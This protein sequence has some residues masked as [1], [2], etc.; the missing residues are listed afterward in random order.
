MASSTNL[1]ICSIDRD[2]PIFEV[3]PSHTVRLVSVNM[4][5]A[6]LFFAVFLSWTPRSDAN[7]AFGPITEP[8]AS[9]VLRSRSNAC[10]GANDLNI[11]IGCVRGFT[12]NGVDKWLGVPFASPPV[13][14]RRFRAP[15]PLRRTSGVIDATQP[16]NCCWGAV[17]YGP[18]AFVSKQLTELVDSSVF[19]E[20]C[21]T[22]LAF[23]PSGRHPER[24][25]LDHERV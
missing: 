20:A 4:R 1:Y 24:R 21:L 8:S 19:P 5:Q 9:S 7:P 25:L 17:C 22:L 15:V 11:D 16:G 6:L 14:D 3:F 2:H 23:R 18:K 12:D 10:N 13:G